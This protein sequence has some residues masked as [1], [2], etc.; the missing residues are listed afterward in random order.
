[1]M[2][3]IIILTF[4]VRQSNN[5]PMVETSKE[6]NKI[7]FDEAMLSIDKLKASI[8]KRKEKWERQRLA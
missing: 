2:M 7:L 8:C 6:A 5:N 4:K 3:M 1:M